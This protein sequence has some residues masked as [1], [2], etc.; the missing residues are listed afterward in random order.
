MTL[1]VCHRCMFNER[2]EVDPWCPSCGGW[3]TV[4]WER[5]GNAS[6]TMNAGST[7]IIGDEEVVS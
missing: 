2:G 5:F 4:Q 6:R 1:R 3:G 7:P